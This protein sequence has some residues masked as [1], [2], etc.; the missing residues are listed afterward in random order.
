MLRGRAQM[1]IWALPFS[2]DSQIYKLVRGE[3]QCVNSSR[4]II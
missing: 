3:Y 4:Q 2:P 1:D